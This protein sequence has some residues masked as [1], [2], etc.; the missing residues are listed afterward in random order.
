MFVA[1]RPASRARSQALVEFALVVP[2]FLL[3]LFALIDFARLEFSYISLANAAREMARVAAISTNSSDTVIDRFNNLA[4][5]ASDWN[6]VNTNSASMIDSVTITVADRCAAAYAA[7][8]AT[9]ALGTPAVPCTTGTL[10]P[11]TVVPGTTSPPV[12]CIL[13]PVHPSLVTPSTPIHGL[14]RAAEG[15]GAPTAP[16]VGGYSCTAPSRS[17]ASG[18]SLHG[19]TVEIVASYQFTFSPLFQ[20]RLTGMIDASFMQQFAVLKTTARAYIE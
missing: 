13:T 16:P 5:I 9:A 14:M 10:N 12:T 4:A 2:L 1:R 6:G 11:P 17:D 19:G 20:N 8:Q 15:A 18:A 3:I 7:A